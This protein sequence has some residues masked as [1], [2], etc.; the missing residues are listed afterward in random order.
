LKKRRREPESP[1]THALY[2]ERAICRGTYLLRVP[3][4]VRGY[5]YSIT[6]ITRSAYPVEMPALCC[7]DPKLPAGILDRHIMSDGMACLA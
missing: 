3:E 1:H 2:A 5:E 6:V 7:N 4:S